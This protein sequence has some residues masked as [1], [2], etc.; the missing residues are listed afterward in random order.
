MAPLDQ[1]NLVRLAIDEGLRTGVDPKIV[2]AQILQESGGNPFAR[3]AAGEQGLMQV[4]PSNAPG[5]NLFDPQANVRA[6]VDYFKQQMDRFQ[7]PQLALSAYN[8]GPTA[9]ARAGDVTPGAAPYVQGVTDKVGQA[10]QLGGPMDQFSP[11]AF[12]PVPF[13]EYLARL[14]GGGNELWHPPMS[15]PGGPPP[16]PGPSAPPPAPENP[17][18]PP[19]PPQ[20]PQ[21]QGGTTA[22][23]ATGVPN[24]IPGPMPS[25]Q[26]MIPPVERRQST[27]RE[28]LQQ[29]GPVLGMA[30]SGGKGFAGALSSFGMGHMEGEAATKLSQWK[31]ERKNKM[32]QEN[33]QVDAAKKLYDELSGLNL[34]DVLAQEQDPA[35]RAVLQGATDKLAALGKKW[36]DFLSPNSEGGSVITPREAGDFMIAAQT[37]KAQIDAARRGVRLGAEQEKVRMAGE[38]TTAEY[39]ARLKAQQEA[40]QNE[41]QVEAPG[42]TGKVPLSRAIKLY[43]LAAHKALLEYQRARAANPRV[44][45]GHLTAAIAA[46]RGALTDLER[47]LVQPIKPAQKQ[48]YLEQKKRLEAEIDQLQAEGGAGLMPPPY[49]GGVREENY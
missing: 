38:T 28:K 16:G 26:G 14:Q 21:P 45:T 6:G 49:A 30:L 41:P 1:Q 20:E 9:T 36:A 5:V 15:I 18:A 8:A 11:A 24:E 19:P 46:K 12:A 17:P 29:L 3:G 34:N 40:E 27:W 32:E 33:A 37:A 39:N 2:Y 22:A 23:A 31:E 10:Q 42:A 48:F 13:D 35:K 43:D 44:A 47:I 25:M 7:T 4:K